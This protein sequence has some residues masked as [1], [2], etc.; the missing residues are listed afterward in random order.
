MLERVKNYLTEFKKS[1]LYDD[2]KRMSFDLTAVFSVFIVYLLIPSSYFPE[3]AK[4]YILSLILTKFI[5][6]SCGNIHFFITR[7]LMYYYIHFSEEKE[8]SNNLMIIVMYAII[9]WG[10]ARGG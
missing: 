3:K 2:I 6:I 1:R 4:T 8:W 5:L 7:K 9:V 10:W